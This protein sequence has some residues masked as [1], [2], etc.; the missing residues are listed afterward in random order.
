MLMYTLG[1]LLPL[2]LLELPLAKHSFIIVAS[3]PGLYSIFLFALKNSSLAW[4]RTR[5]LGL[6]RPTLYQLSYKRRKNFYLCFYLTNDSLKF[7]KCSLSWSAASV[8]CEAPSAL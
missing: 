7:Q 4:V 6:I 8:V 5:D 1:L 2:G 3:V